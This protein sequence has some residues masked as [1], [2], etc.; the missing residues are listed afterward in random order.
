MTPEEKQKAIRDTISALN[1]EAYDEANQIK[2][3]VLKSGDKELIE[4]IDYIWHVL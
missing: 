4:T 2:Q 1:G 3:N